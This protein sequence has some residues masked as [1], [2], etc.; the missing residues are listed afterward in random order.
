MGGNEPAGKYTFSVKS[1]MRIM[2]YRYCTYFC[3]MYS[4]C[5]T[6]LITDL[7]IV[8]SGEEYKL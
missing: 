6:H 5:P 2:N 1:E 4:T 8:M 7:L 3:P